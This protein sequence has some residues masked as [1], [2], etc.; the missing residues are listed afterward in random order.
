MKTTGELWPKLEAE[1]ELAVRQRLAD[2]VYA[3]DDVASVEEWLR[4]QEARRAE[5]VEHAQRSIDRESLRLAEEANSI[6][7]EANRL[8]GRANIVAWIALAVAIGGIVA[9]W[10]HR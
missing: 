5:I 2:K 7:R 4:Q 3:P 10:M 8:A 9:A 1:G 6:S